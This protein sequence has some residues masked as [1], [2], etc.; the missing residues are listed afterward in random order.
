MF[1]RPVNHLHNRPSLALALYGLFGLACVQRDAAEDT[2]V[3]ESSES[4]ANEEGDDTETSEATGTETE[5]GEGEPS[6]GP[7]PGFDCLCVYR[8]LI[9]DPE[10]PLA[11]NDC[12]LPSPCPIV[13]GSAEA[14]ECVLEMLIAQEPGRFRYS[15]ESTEACGTGQYTWNGWFYILLGGEDASQRIGFDNECYIDECNSTVS[16]PSSETPSAQSYE[17][18]EPAYFADCLG[19]EADVMTA[20]IFNGLSN[21]GSDISQCD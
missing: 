21:F 5:T 14:A 2:G 7:V 11:L 16:E 15:Y 1:G 18:E 12:D 4:P 17:L 9:C 6:T 13:D 10:A 20:C 8:D 3:A 19:K